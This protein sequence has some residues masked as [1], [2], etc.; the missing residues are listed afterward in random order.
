[1]RKSLLVALAVCVVALFSGSVALAADN[2][3]GTWKLNVEKSKASPGPAP[4][5]LTLKFEATKDGTRFTS[6]GVSADGKPMHGTYTS[7]FDGKDVPWEGNPEADTA[8]PMKIDDSSYENVWK[9]GGKVT[10]TAKA[11][12]SKDGKTLTISQTGKNVKGEAVNA[13]VVFEKQ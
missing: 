4:K 3:L 1:M 12:V 9:K 6:D 11:V 2:W 10:I 5:S 7:K 8:A 13:N